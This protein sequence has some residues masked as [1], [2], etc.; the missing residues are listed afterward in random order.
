MRT[1]GQKRARQGGG[2]AMMRKAALHHPGFNSQEDEVIMWR[3][4]DANRVLTDAEWALFSTGLD[5]LWKSIEENIRSRTIGGET[6]VLVFDRLT[7][8]QKLALLA[9]TALALRDPAIPMPRHTAANEGA[10]AAVF[11]MIRVELETEL[12]IASMEGEEKP[13]VVR[14]MLRELCDVSEER[15]E[16]LPDETST[17]F[18]E[19]EWLLEEFEDRIFWDCDFEMGDEFL[20]LPPEEAR[21]KL[22][23]CRIDPDYYLAVPDEPDKAD[24][25]AA[26][27]TLARLLSLP[28]PDDGGLYPAI[29][30]LYHSLAIGPCSPD[31]IATWEGRPWVQVVRLAEPGWDCDY[32]TW[33]EKLSR[34]LPSTPFQLVPATAEAVYELSSRWSIVRRGDTWVVQDEA[35][36]Y[37]CGLIENGWTSNPDDKEMPALAFPTEAEARSAFAQADRMYDER[38]KR[39]ERALAKL[40]QADV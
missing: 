26:R 28:V 34:E 29:D 31:Q 39:Y 1:T 21:E 38:A 9:D 20:D 7:P 36:S 5:L 18:D 12:D 24:L 35:G 15:E 4:Q 13:I 3:M 17:D 19:W 11:S 37:W 14:R 6:S 33:T 23:L 25:I 40:G 2:T 10:I 30:D 32:A 22:E 8:E 16:P 27:Q